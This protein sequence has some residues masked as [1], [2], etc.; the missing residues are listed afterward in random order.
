MLDFM[1]RKYHG[2][3]VVESQTD[4]LGNYCRLETPEAIERTER[5]IG[6]Y[7]REH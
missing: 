5:H 7:V 6:K 2:A 1:L 4:I 3:G